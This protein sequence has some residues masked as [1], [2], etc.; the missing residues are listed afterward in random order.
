MLSGMAVPNEERIV[1]DRGG[2]VVAERGPLIVV[3]DRA[4]G[5][6]A[7]VGFVLGVIAVITGGFGM[8][9]LIVA[10]VGGGLVG[11]PIPYG[12]AFV[13]AGLLIAFC[14]VLV[15]RAI[16]ERRDR[17]LQTYR[18]VAIFDR[19]RRV[20]A[21]ADGHV[22]APLEQVRFRKAMQIGSSSPKLVAYS[23]YGEWVLKR[24]NPFDGGIG[25]LDEVL[26][27]AVHGNI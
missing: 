2:V 14:V 3:I 12:V 4:T 13:A 17:P 27:G 1:V 8:I 26:T 11:L 16:R 22:L 7:T 15:L 9:C 6:M 23:P 10:I 24:G 25:N 21:D 19:A 5:M 18:P 20:F